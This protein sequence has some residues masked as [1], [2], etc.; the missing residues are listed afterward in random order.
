M[1]SRLMAERIDVG[2]SGLYAC[3]A[4]SIPSGASSGH[5]LGS[6]GSG[7]GS[8]LGDSSSAGGEKLRRLFGL[9]VNG[10]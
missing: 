9:V 4:E 6:S 1:R 5:S 2:H 3:E 8:S 10:K 7:S